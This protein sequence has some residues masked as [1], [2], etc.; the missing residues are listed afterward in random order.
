MDSG[1]VSGMRPKTCGV[2]VTYNPPHAEFL[3]LV[4]AIRP[5]LDMLFVIDN[6]DGGQLPAGLQERDVRVICLGENLGIARAQNVGIEQA[7]GGDYGFVLLLDQDSLPAPDM[8]ALLL[9]AHDQAVREGHAVAAVGPSYLDDRQ[10]EIAPFVYRK[11]LSLRRRVRSED[12]N[13]TEADFLI[14]S[15]CLIPRAALAKV[16]LMR[17]EMFIDYVDI[18]WG[19]RAQSLGLKSFG[20]HAALMSHSLGDKWASWKG[21]KIPLHSALRHY[22]HI[23]NAIWLARQGWIDLPWKLILLRRVVLQLAFFSVRGDHRLDQVKMMLLGVWH[24]LL[25]RTGRL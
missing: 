16:G 15:G 13:F 2:I 14:A 23:R 12:E 20:V 22:Y 11:G 18:E 5:Q 8:V 4:D 6:G 17:E 19:L 25:G 24:G 7:L 9:Q 21:R 3:K 1:L 10:G